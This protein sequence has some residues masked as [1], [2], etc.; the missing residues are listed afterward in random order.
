[1]PTLKTDDYEA[2]TAAKRAL[3]KAKEIE[4]ETIGRLERVRIDSK[5]VILTRPGQAER[6]KQRLAAD[7]QR[8]Q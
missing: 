4:A 7:R 2:M 8:Y 6:F 3:A 1:M 5:T